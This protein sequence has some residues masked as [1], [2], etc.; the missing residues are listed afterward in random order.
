M[1]NSKLQ[2][3]LKQYPDDLDIKLLSEKSEVV[4]YTGETLLLTSET[5]HVD[6][7]ADEEDW[8]TEDGKIV[9]GDGKQYLLLNCIIV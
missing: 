2:E 8:D 3:L 4:D 7:S 9:L 1:K 6:D 5:A